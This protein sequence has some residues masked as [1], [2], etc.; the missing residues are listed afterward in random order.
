MATLRKRGKTWYVDFRCKGRRTRKAAGKIKSVAEAVLKDIEVKIAKGE[1]LRVYDEPKI[2][3]RDF[4]KEYL[5]YSK[6]NKSPTSFERDVS[7][8]YHLLQAFG[9][10]FLTEITSALIERYKQ[11]R[12]QSIKPATVNRELACLKHMFSMAQNW[13]YTKE[14]PVKKVK[15]LKEPPGRLR[16]LTEKEIQDLLTVCQGRLYS[17]VFTALYTGMRKSELLYLRWKDIDF[18][19]K[20]ITLRKTKNNEMRI[21]PVN[22]TLWREF[23]LLYLKRRGP[24]VFSNRE[25]P[26]QNLDN[27]FAKALK[28]AGI[29]DFRFHDLRHTFAS[30]LVMKGVDIRTVQKLMG[31][32]NIKMTLRY[33]HLS[34]DHERTAINRLDFGHSLGTLE[35]HRE[36]KPRKALILNG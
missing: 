19:N 14:N 9:D 35:G 28:E 27:A 33:A 13:E 32:K 24:Y 2:L 11:R 4:S 12:L 10:K 3:F 34:P 6:A 20:T 16:Y 31:H 21:I 22:E 18:Q 8:M 17:I 23:R 15:L 30:H 1:H 7:I 25:K 36:T 29:K 26:Y 5:K